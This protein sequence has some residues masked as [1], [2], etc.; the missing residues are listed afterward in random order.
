MITEIRNDYN[1]DEGFTTI[2]VWEDDNENGRVVAVVH[3]S[4]DVFFID[5]RLRFDEEVQTAIKE[6][7]ERQGIFE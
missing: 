3:K 4:G 2:D 1:N 6:V 7:K 5:N